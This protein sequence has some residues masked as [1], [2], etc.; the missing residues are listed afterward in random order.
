M[1]P[2]G[3]RWHATNYSWAKYSL[4][5]KICLKFFCYSFREFN[6]YTFMHP[7]ISLDRLESNSMLLCKWFDKDVCKQHP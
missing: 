1:S 2:K 4:V 3:K 6:L 7:T 5:M